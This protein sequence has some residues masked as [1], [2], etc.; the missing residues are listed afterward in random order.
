MGQRVNEY[1][2]PIGEPM[3]NWRPAKAPGDQSMT[4]RY[5]RLERVNV[6]RHLDDLYDAYSAAPDARDW[7]YLSVGPFD[8]R[9]AYRDC[10]T[11]LAA[12]HDP[13]HYAVIDLA[14]GKAVGTLSLMRIDKT[15][16]VIEVG[17]VVFSQRL[18]KTRMATEAIFLLMQRV[19]DD[20]G[21][22]R[23]EWKCDALNAPSR[24]AAAR[25]GFTFEGIFRQAVTYKGRNRNTAWFSII[26][27]E[28]PALRAGFAEWLDEANFDAQGTQRRTLQ[29][30]M[31]GRRK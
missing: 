25:F 28:W 21:Y 16:G 4:G 8:T 27:S 30:C 26:D 6:E 23:F 17:F 19:F 29:A 14:T 12:S 18:Q 7:T 5:C 15:N 3:P 9:E 11:A 10:L 13:L 24:A 20:L 22:R 1:G 2:Q 31:A